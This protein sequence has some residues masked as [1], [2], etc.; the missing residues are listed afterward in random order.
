MEMSF[1][2]GFGAS[3]LG[4]HRGVVRGLICPKTT[5]SKARVELAL[6]S[7]VKDLGW[8]RNSIAWGN[9]SSLNRC[10]YIRIY[11]HV[12]SIQN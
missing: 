1:R 11:A 10:I 6:N 4:S 7:G 12:R 9:V 2:F 3:T 5:G 8:L